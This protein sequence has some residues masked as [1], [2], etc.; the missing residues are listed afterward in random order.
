[1]TTVAIVMLLA[2]LVFPIGR[3]DVVVARVP[4]RVHIHGRAA[5]AT[6]PGDARDHEMAKRWV[7]QLN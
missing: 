1:M 3:S 4:V 2:I 6:S 7:S 5:G